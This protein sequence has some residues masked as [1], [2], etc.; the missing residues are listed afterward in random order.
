MTQ[1][2]PAIK[3][4]RR[5]CHFFQLNRCHPR[6]QGLRPIWPKR[7]SKRHSLTYLLQHWLSKQEPSTPAPSSTTVSVFLKCIPGLRCSPCLPPPLPRNFLLPHLQNHILAVSLTQDRWFFFFRFPWHCWES[8]EHQH[9][10]LILTLLVWAAPKGEQAWL[11]LK[12]RSCLLHPGRFLWEMDYYLAREGGKVHGNTQQEMLLLPLAW[13]LGTGGV[14]R[15]RL[16]EHPHWGD[17]GTGSWLGLGKQELLDFRPRLTHRWFKAHR[18]D[19]CC[20]L[21]KL[22]LPRGESAYLSPVKYNWLE[23]IC[24]W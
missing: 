20:T 17:P 13:N 15:E 14:F 24:W 1:Q 2:V 19:E 10:E 5:C 6:E 21:G 16:T 22:R 9:R 7:E 8:N 12:L 3:G 18:K 23:M 4:E 11:P